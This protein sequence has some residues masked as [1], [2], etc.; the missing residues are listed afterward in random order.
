MLSSIFVW[1]C[2]AWFKVR[3]WRIP[4]RFPVGLKQYVLAVAPHTSN[5]DFPVGVAARRLLGLNVKFVAKAELFKFPVRSIL[6]NL[7]GYPVDRSKKSNFVDQVVELFQTKNDFAICVTPEG[8]RS[9]VET[10]KTGF[11]HMAVKAGVPIIMVGFDYPMRVV[12]V[13]DPFQPT[14]DMETD[15]ARMDQFFEKI[16]P[17]HPENSKYH[18][19]VA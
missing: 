18:K 1:L 12:V 8:T 3:G 4:K 7:G 2:V 19:V 16:V 14:G 9:R 17:K 11:Y 13:S 5:I 10:W 15:F 6:L